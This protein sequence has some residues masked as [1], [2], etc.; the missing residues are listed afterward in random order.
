MGPQENSYSYRW[1]A[2]IGRF[3]LVSLSLATVPV[4]ASPKTDSVDS[5]IIDGAK[6]LSAA[7]AAERIDAVRTEIAYH[8]EL[9]FKKSAPVISDNA[10]DRLK[11]ELAALEQRFPEAMRKDGAVETGVG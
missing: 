1:F 4:V 8:D 5:S 10:Y 9:Y 7:E 6:Q 2:Q 11:R 3:V